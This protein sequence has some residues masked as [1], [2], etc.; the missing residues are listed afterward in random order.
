MFKVFRVIEM[1]DGKLLD[2]YWGSWED[3]ERANEVALELRDGTCF[4]TY[5]I[6]E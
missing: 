4:S 3:K 5:V 2:C 6:E 1:E